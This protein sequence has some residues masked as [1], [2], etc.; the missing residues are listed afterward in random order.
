MH[1]AA[2]YARL[3]RNKAL[4]F[5]AKLIMAGWLNVEEFGWNKLFVLADLHQVNFYKGLGEMERS[6]P[7]F[8]ID[9]VSIQKARISSKDDDRELMAEDVN[10]RTFVLLYDEIGERVYGPFSETEKK[11]WDLHEYKGHLFQDV[12][13]RSPTT[14][15]ACKQSLWS[16]RQPPPAVNC[17]RC[18][19][20]VH[21]YHYDEDDG[22]VNPCPRIPI[23][24]PAKHGDGLN[25]RTLRLKADTIEMKSTW[26]S[27]INNS[28]QHRSEIKS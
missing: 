10:S 28:V 19:T 16:I 21:T 20:Q 18:N 2:F 17:T 8:L 15:D 4:I 5:G 12:Q 27:Y 25:L 13:N 24:T 22:S 6:S 3:R 26:I 14:C 11:N 9:L 7:V 1:A 23:G